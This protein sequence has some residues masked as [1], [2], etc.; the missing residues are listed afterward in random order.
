MRKYII[1]TCCLV[2]GV[3]L[4]AWQKAYGS[5]DITASSIDVSARP[6]TSTLIYIIHGDGS[7]RYHDL[8]GKAYDADKET[9]A[10]ALSVAEN[11]VTTEVFIFHLQRKRRWFFIWPR[12]DSDF[13]YYR[14]GKRLAKKSYNRDPERPN[15]E[16]ETGFYHQ[17]ALPSHDVVDTQP[18]ARI[19]LY[20]GHEI[21]EFG[22]V[23]Y[24][25]SRPDMPFNIHNMTEG[26][27]AFTMRDSGP[28]AKFDLIVLSSCYSGT[29]GIISSLAL[30]A[31]YI[32]ASP[33]ELHLSYID[34]HLLRTLDTIPDF[35]AY[36]FSKDFAHH[37]FEH[38]DQS[39]HTIITLS[40]YDTEK[41]DVPR[42][43]QIADQYTRIITVAEQ[44][45]HGSK[46][47]G[48]ACED[49]PHT[50]GD[51]AAVGVD[52]WYR[53]PRFGRLKDKSTHSGWGCWRLKQAD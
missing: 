32:L 18:S 19:L 37:A 10:Q 13:Y 35:Q 36:E 47:V 40:L 49:L 25:A 17:Y 22:G 9:L 51:D 2:I 14:G 23:G 52:I 20:Y 33:A 5:G 30:Y 15:W 48:M 29:P 27:Q 31:R 26:I 7:Y 42:L 8:E 53:A 1:L 4:S 6:I 21:P 44:N 45:A 16:I 46:T 39:T 43:K 38:L 28:A 34:S 12:K 50:M 11:T 3:G 24:Y 41:I